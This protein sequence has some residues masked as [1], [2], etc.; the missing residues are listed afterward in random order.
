[1]CICVQLQQ[2][3]ESMLVI[4]ARSDFLGEYF[5]VCPAEAFAKKRVRMNMVSRPFTSAKML[6]V[7]VGTLVEL[8]GMIQTISQ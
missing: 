2:T 8:Y 7:G 4:C 1:M 6:S 5:R 3:V